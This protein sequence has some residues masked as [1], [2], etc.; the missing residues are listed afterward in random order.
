M[1]APHLG[2]PPDAH[3]P[4]A[5]KDLL[6]LDVSRVLAGPYCTMVLGDYGAR[7]VKVE[8]PTRGDDT[9]HWGPPFTAA[10]ESAYFLTAN[11]NKQSITLNL[12]DAAGKA[13]FLEL[14]QRADVLVE[15]FRVNALDQLGL[16]YAAC[17][18]VNPRLVY[19]AI[20]GYGQTGPYA[21]L[22]GYDNIIE[23]QGGIMSITGPDEGTA[24]KVGVAIVDI[25]AG[26]HAA[27]AILG[28]LRHRDATGE[29]QYIDVALLDV[30]LSWLA[31]VASAYLV[32]GAPPQ[33]YGNAHPSIV[34][35]QT[36][37]TADGLL[38]LA[39]GNDRQ[40]GSLCR[41]LELE[42]LAGDPNYCTNAARVEHRATLIPLLENEFCKRTTRQWVELLHAQGI[43]CGPV[44][45]IPT[46]LHDPQAQ[47]RG[48]VQ[49]V[50]HPA[51]E[52]I[53]QIGPP[54][55]LSATP[56][57]VQSAPPHLGEHTATVLNELLG[58][59]PTTIAA[60]RQQGVI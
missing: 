60:L 24:S 19:C 21:H 22:P 28:A 59:D 18:A 42:T 55:K 13:I 47:A 26:L 6:I 14:V 2:I 38:M 49:S 1:G 25:T 58:M 54:I 44:N 33:R 29:G 31:N 36:F 4:A 15:N 8:E 51:G 37:A 27:I 11:R 3:P 56:P 17:R 43:P 52:E 9:R 10:G 16:G 45:D 30:Q 12:K 46:A 41:V 32:S 50:H 35:Y 39:V 57:R 48:M 5:L 40:F 7:V 20:T 34:P 53:P 23:A